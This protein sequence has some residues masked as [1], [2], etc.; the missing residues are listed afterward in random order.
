MTGGRGHRVTLVG[1]LVVASLV[2]TTRL[3]AHEI[4]PGFLEI[5]ET[6][7]RQFSVFFK[8]PLYYGEVLN[9]NPVLPPGCA[10]LTPVSRRATTDALFERW[11]VGCEADLVGQTIA[12]EG[13]ESLLTDVLVQIRLLDGTSHTVRLRPVATSF[14][15]PAEPSAWQVATTY[16][17]L[18]VE[19]ILSGIDHLLFV[20]A[21]L[22]LVRGRWMLLK[23]ITAFTIA[24]SI[25]LALASLG[26][27]QVPGA[28]VEAVIAVSIVFLASELARSHLGRPGL[29]QRFP[30]VVAFSFGLLHGLGFAGALAEIGLPQGQIPLALFQFNVGV[31]AGQLLFVA[32]ALG[33]GWGIRRTKIPQPVWARLVPA[34]AIGAIAVFWTLQRVASF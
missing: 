3:S 17:G 16:L 13:L 5:E 27:V 11:H 12:I 24:H 1:L 15:V 10:I 31:E 26:V 32:A 34:Y 19:H 14:V 4:R 20:L 6:A 30:W 9:M 33:V 21:L 7:P 25:T 23:T 28:P 29:T 18:G 8:T 2:A 22:L